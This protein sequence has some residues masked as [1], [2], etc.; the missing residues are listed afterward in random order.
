MA[1]YSSMR[2]RVRADRVGTIGAWSISQDVDK[3]NK[4]YYHLYHYATR[5][6][7]W[8]RNEDGTAEVFYT[9]IG[10]GSVSDQQGVNAALYELNAPMRYARN[11]G[12]A[13]YEEIKKE[14]YETV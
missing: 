5:M 9:N 8:Y 11:G 14:E 3:D 10:H 6:V 2:H 13:R 12:Y 1:S 4:T 7:S